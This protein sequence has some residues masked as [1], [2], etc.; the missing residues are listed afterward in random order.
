M[1]TVGDGDCAISIADQLGC[2]DYHTVW[3][4]GVNS[5]VK[6]LRS[7]PNQLV[8]GDE[9]KPPPGKTKTVGKAVD[10]TWTFVVPKKKLTKLNLVIVDKDDKPLAGKAWR[11]TAPVAESG[12]TKANGLIAI[13]DL[14]PKAK[15]GT[16]EVDWRKTKTPKKKAAPK[17][18]KITTPV[19]P[20]PI[21]PAEFKDVDPAA[22]LPADDTMEW[23]LKIGSLP[24]F[25]NAGGVQARLNN[26]GFRCDPDAQAGRT[27][28]DVKTYQRTRLKSKTPSG[29]AADIQ[30]DVQKRHDNP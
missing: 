18:P 28:D 2:N 25:K 24:D 19:Y 1:P 3:D 20:R 21:T 17:V 13:K 15:A 30:A 11:L 29:V 23:A 10:A 22:P 14:D 7:N 8:V 5:A 4:D 16:L 12:T 27:Q 26:L 9:V 6:K